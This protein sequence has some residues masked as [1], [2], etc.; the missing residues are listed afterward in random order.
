MSDARLELWEELC[1]CGGARKSPDVRMCS[2]NAPFEAGL[3]CRDCCAGVFL[4][5]SGWR[6]KFFWGCSMY[7]KKG[8][9]N[10]M[11]FGPPHDSAARARLTGRYRDPAMA[12]YAQISRAGATARSLQSSRA[13][14]DLPSDVEVRAWLQSQGMED[15]LW[16]LRTPIGWG[17]LAWHQAGAEG[18]VD[19]CRW[20]L[21][22]GVGDLINAK[23]SAGH[24]ALSFCAV[25]HRT[26][27]RPGTQ[28]IKTA[29]WL[30][31]HGANPALLEPED[32]ATLQAM[33][34]GGGSNKRS[35]MHGP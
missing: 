8:C 14:S 24:T 31:A 2:C 12:D 19:M 18:R 11:K 35:N 21:S 34:P 3:I 23:S 13:D 16:N 5:K 9:K 27:F 29:K 7:R 4:I 20:L 10:T 33:L 17:F 22:R 15:M 1:H 25:H 28:Y 6:G 30:L 32:K 26:S